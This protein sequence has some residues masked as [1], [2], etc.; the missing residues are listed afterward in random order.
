MQNDLRAAYQT[1]PGPLLPFGSGY[2]YGTETAN[3]IHAVRK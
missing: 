3:L 1:A 2:H